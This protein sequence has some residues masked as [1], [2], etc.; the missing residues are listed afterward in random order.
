MDKKLPPPI[1]KEATAIDA[2]PDPGNHT[3]E[4]ELLRGHAYSAALMR[5]K[6]PRRPIGN[7]PDVKAGSPVRRRDL[8][9]EKLVELC[10]RYGIPDREIAAAITSAAEPR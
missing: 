7:A 2:L 1:V 6:A 9:I 10:R 5:E 3:S 4:P 8:Q